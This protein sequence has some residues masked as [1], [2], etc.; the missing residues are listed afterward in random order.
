[1]ALVVVVSGAAARSRITLPGG[2]SAVQ[3]AAADGHG[4][5]LADSVTAGG[6]TVTVVS[7]LADSVQTVLGIQIDGMDELGALAAPISRPSLRDSGGST[8]SATAIRPD[9]HQPRAQTWV[10]PPLSATTSDL[11][12]SIDGLR[13][14]DRPRNP[15]VTGPDSPQPMAFVRTEFQVLLSWSGSP[16]QA[17]RH[18]VGHVSAR[19]GPGMLAVDAFTVGP[20]RLVIT[21]HLAGVD[22]DDVPNIELW[23][24]QLTLADGRVLSPVGGRSGFGEQRA[25]FEFRFESAEADGATFRVPFKVSDHPHDAA[26]ANSLAAFSGSVATVRL[27]AID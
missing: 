2:D 13:F 6:V 20:T 8:Y 11:M 15:A 16:E 7:I 10:F 1:M 4:T 5:S 17:V 26:R 12:L 21:G 19:F 23:P 18:N 27:D 22:P 9:Q 25:Q 14:W 24:P 3:I